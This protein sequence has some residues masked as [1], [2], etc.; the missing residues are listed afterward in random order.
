MVGNAY[1]RYTFQVLGTRFKQ[2]CAEQAIVNTALD[3][4][5]KSRAC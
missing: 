5:D 1:T 2:G 4:M 3:L